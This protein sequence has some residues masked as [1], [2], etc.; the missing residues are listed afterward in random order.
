MAVE[1][2]TKNKVRPVIDF[3]EL[4]KSARRHMGDCMTHVYSEKIREWQQ[5]EGDVERVD[6]KSAYLQIRI[7]EE[8][9]QYISW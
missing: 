5:I 6:M 8:L 1:Q 9:R 3:R 4:N 7:V 2:P